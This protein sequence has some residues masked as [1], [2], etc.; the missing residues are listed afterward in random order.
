MTT[1]LRKKVAQEFFDYSDKYNYQSDQ[2]GYIDTPKD[3]SNQ[4]E[5]QWYQSV[6]IHTP[7]YEFTRLA[8]IFELQTNPPPQFFYR[9]EAEYCVKN[10]STQQWSIQKAAV[11]VPKKAIQKTTVEGIIQRWQHGLP[12]L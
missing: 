3:N 6:K 8:L 2:Q 12:K 7:D 9:I 11:V 10:P 1:K 4:P 5:V